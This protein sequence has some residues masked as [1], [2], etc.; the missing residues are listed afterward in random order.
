MKTTEFIDWL[1]ELGTGKVF[2]FM[3][4]VGSIAA[5]IALTVIYFHVRS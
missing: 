3:A 5:A 1:H 4:I 2:A